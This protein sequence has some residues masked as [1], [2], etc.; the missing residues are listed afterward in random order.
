MIM[1]NIKDLRLA[2]SENTKMLYHVAVHER[3]FMCA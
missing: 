3:A 2:S 1:A